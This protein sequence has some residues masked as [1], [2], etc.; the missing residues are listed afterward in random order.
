MFLVLRPNS[1]IAI[2]KYNEF[3]FVMMPL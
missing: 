1:Y 2:L 3:Q